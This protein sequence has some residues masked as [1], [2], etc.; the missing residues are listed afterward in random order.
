MLQD[1][2][3]QSYDRINSRSTETPS[4][5]SLLLE[6]YQ[7]SQST[8]NYS[9]GREMVPQDKVSVYRELISPVRWRMFEYYMRVG[10][11]TVYALRFNLYM[12]SARA[13][14]NHKALEE[15][16]VVEPKAQVQPIHPMK[17]PAQIWGLPEATHQQIKDAYQLHV[18]LI[19]PRY[20]IAY[21]HVRRLDDFIQRVP[22]EK[23][24]HIHL[25]DLG[26]LPHERRFLT[27]IMLMIYKEEAR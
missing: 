19:N 22:T 2:V 4:L 15:Y 6:L 26:V 24:I 23:E 5:S 7:L 14:R 11:S 1:K 12:K 27:T 8:E 9:Y 17:R 13:Y 10:A 3:T 20:R 25:K 16:G 21:G 18:K